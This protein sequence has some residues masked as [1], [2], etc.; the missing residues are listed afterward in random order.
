MFDGMKD[1]M[2][3]FQIMQRLM[4]DD[5]FKAFIAH[6][7]VQEVFK[8]SEFKEI[9]KSRD[10]SKILS[11]PKFAALMRDPELAALMAKINPQSFM[12]G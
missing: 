4:T 8:D 2:G 9:A 6:P 3:Q 1:M 12:Q 5:N 11:N 10:F 7:K